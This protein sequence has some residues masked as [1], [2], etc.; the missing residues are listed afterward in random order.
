MTSAAPFLFDG[1]E[2]AA[3]TLLLAHGADPTA[4]CLGH[5]ALGW[6]RVNRLATVVE[7]LEAAVE[8]EVC[9][10]ATPA[11]VPS[12]HLLTLSP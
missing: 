10:P 3:T 9:R 6:A 12:T 7:L 1:P 2:G 11:T 5:D 4:E 8:A